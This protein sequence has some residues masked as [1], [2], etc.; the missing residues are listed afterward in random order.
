M[1]GADAPSIFLKN[2]VKERM[3]MDFKNI[4]KSYR[5]IPFWSWNEKLN[6]E[7]T[8]RQAELMDKA[9][10]GGF[11]MH[12]RG[13]LETEYMSEQWF[14]NVAAAVD[15][16]KKLG[17]EAWAYDENG[18]PSG[19]GSGAVNGL[20]LEYRQKYLRI[21]QDKPEKNIITQCGGYWFYYDVNPFYIDALDKKTV[22]KFI[23]VSY[24]PYYK[25]FGNDIKGFFTDEPQ[26]SRDGYPWSFVLEEKYEERYGE[27]LLSVIDELF[28]CTG[29]YKRT[30]IRYWKLVTDLFSE[31]Y[32]KQIYDWC[33]ERGLGFS[34]HL[35]L[36]EDLLSQL[37]ANGACM[38]HYE[39][40]TMPGMDWL[41]RNIKKCLTSL[42][43]ASA[44][45]QTGKTAVIS[46]TFALCGHN[47]SFAELKGIFEWQMVH[48][49]TRLCQH[50]EGYSMRGIRKRD[51][52]PA[53]FY[54]QAWWNDYNKFIDALSREGM[55]LSD[56]FD[57]QVLVIHPQ[58]TAWSMFD[59]IK[60]DGIE[61][62]SREFL[63][64]CDML[65]RKHIPYHLGDETIMERHAK[66]VGAAI[67]IGG[68]IYKCVV[69][70]PE[71][72]L[73]AHTRAL[74][75]EFE[76]GG[77]IIVTDAEAMASNNVTDNEEISYAVRSC[78]GH[79]VHYF[80]N[81][82]GE[83]KRA[84]INVC[85]KKLDIYSGTL[86][87]FCSDYE[88]EPWGSLMIIDDG[89][90]EK[91]EQKNYIRANLPDKMKILEPVENVLTL[92][93]CTYY[94]DGK[95]EEENGYV[96]NITG[97]A[98]N[99]KRPVKILMEYSVMAEYIPDKMYMA[100]ETPEQFMIKI[101]GKEIEK[102]QCG[103]FRD[104]SFKRLDISDFMKT[105]ENIITLECNFLQSERF[106]KNLEK[107]KKF[108]SEKNK[109][110]YDMEIE[111]IYFIGNFGVKS[112]GKW[113]QLQRDA[114]RY[115]GK[116]V[117][118]RQPEYVYIRHIEKSGFP[119]FCGNMTLECELE[120]QNNS[121]I[122]FERKGVNV[123]SVNNAADK[124]I[125]LTENRYFLP[126][127]GNNKLE[128]TVTNNLR[129]ML[130]PHHL[131]EGE[132]YY[133][134]PGSFFKEPCIWN[135]NPQEEWNDDYCFA[136]VGI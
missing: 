28:N 92:D 100:V 68:Q 48:G 123:I 111:P 42:Q 54:Q 130:G 45:R 9:G 67:K 40:F 112:D 115:R 39:Y 58:T 66:T 31:S 119:F 3:M 14:E 71:Y 11:F 72:I 16:A 110:V 129:N 32:F 120:A 27:E 128:I 29:E 77:G 1:L 8:K 70:S 81:T 63:N 24:E 38:P 57:P 76:K 91:A 85:G 5:P 131:A 117:I 46:E 4:P 78:G 12:A 86:E 103:Y 59:S 37:T 124:K 23:E 61:K 80:V 21:S 2:Y 60:N 65:E 121:Y 113:T 73:L 84:K 15:E 36:E 134:H 74:L 125:L 49:V 88:F 122:E 94:F 62:L 25:R 89:T 114:V 135:G 109:L 18:W 75:D 93:R 19:F 107:A 17:M 51:Y 64:V 101:N 83:Y 126:K 104:I 47:V 79:K 136:V 30:R 108:E 56:G 90:K 50:L 99:L 132:S 106:Y 52:P 118:A 102:R 41:G 127:G 22:K 53:M 26:L 96:L 35:L 7:E 133:V 87:K 20:G 6:T 55:I 34:G 98:V 10:I 116:F 95:L 69:L 13:G 97:R 44:A 43:A 105:G 82:S 33:T